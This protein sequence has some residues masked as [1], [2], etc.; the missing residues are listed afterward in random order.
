M[1]S[2]KLRLW[3][4]SANASYI[5]GTELHVD[6]GAFLLGGANQDLVNNSKPGAHGHR[7]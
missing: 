4:A 6:G 2:P 5:S 1:P 7:P 3:L